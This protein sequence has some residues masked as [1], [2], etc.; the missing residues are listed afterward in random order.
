VEGDCGTFHV[1][2]P[3]LTVTSGPSNVLILLD[4]SSTMADPSRA[5][6]SKWA[7]T[8]YALVQ[9][10]ADASALGDVRFGLLLFPGADVVD[11]CS[12]TATCCALSA[13]GQDVDV[14]IGP[15]SQR[16]ILELLDATTPGGETPTAD[17]LTRALEYFT[18]GP[19]ASLN[20][21]K[22]A[23]VITDGSPNCNEPN[24]CQDPQLCA[25][26]NLD[27]L[28]AAGI[29][30][31]VI[32]PPGPPFVDLQAEGYTFERDPF[33][34]EE[35]YAGALSWIAGLITL[36][37]CRV[38]LGSPY[39]VFRPFGVALGCSP[40]PPDLWTFRLDRSGQGVTRVTFW[41]ETCLQ[42]AE[43]GLP[44]LTLLQGCPRL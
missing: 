32:S 30:S 15:D 3:T 20:G 35:L 23:V 18:V 29:D 16:R 11:P 13:L 25:S 37:A 2:A 21:R 33:P 39:R 28:V 41:G 7:A 26:D 10:M 22:Y 38:D 24:T 31:F 36:P 44:P 43:S 40:L 4:K 1:D 6:V 8:Q 5:R 42:L 17:A 19:G 12:T 27:A 14:P 9:A 34:E